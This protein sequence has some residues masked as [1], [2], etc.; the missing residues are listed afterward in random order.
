MVKQARKC[1]VC[2]KLIREWNKSGLC[3]HHYRLRE[4]RKEYNV[5]CTTCKEKLKE[6]IAYYKT[7]PY[8]SKC[9]RLEK[10][11]VLIRTQEDY[12]EWLNKKA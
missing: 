2:G 7:K 11:G 1:S 9:F 8:C 12:I 4:K 10:H 5:R 6:P 3:Q